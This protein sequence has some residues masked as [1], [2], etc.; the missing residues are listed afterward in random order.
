MKNR[1][2][3]FLTLNKGFILVHVLIF[4]MFF[5]STLSLMIIQKKLS[6]E[7][8]HFYQM[9]QMRVKTE[10]EVI[11]IIKESIIWDDHKELML[12]NQKVTINYDDIIF[13]NVCSEVCYSMLIEF[14]KEKS[15]IL[16]ISYE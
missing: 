10:K 6:L 9:A 12:F 2:S 3:W 4:F 1:L 15:V 8:M 11:K 16:S 13:V 7:Q 14:D 5:T